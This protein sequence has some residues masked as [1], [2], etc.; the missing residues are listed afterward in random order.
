[1]EQKWSH[2]FLK[3]IYGYQR[4][5]MNGEINQELEINMHTLLYKK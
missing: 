2:R 3:Q 5:N 1:M 4:R